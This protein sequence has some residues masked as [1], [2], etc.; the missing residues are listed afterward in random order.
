MLF[1]LLSYLMTTIMTTKTI[2]I[3][4]FFRQYGKNKNRGRIRVTLRER[5]DGWICRKSATTSFRHKIISALISIHLITGLLKK[6]V[7]GHEIS[8]RSPA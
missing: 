4:D 7:A 8:V 5:N 6:R 3:K 2:A 1:S